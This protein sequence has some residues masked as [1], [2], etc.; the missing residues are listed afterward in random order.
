MGIGGDGSAPPVAGRRGFADGH[1]LGAAYLDGP[2]ELAALGGGLF[3]VVDG[4]NNAL[5]VLGLG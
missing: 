5:R 1:R 2:L 3:A 4:R